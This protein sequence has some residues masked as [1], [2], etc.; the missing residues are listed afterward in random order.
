MPANI[1][2]HSDEYRDEMDLVKQWMDE[3]LQAVTGS[4][5]K[6]MN[7]YQSF[8]SWQEN[9]GHHPMTSNVFYRLLPSHLGKSIKKP[10]GSYYSGYVVKPW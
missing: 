4:S 8:R 2:R 10:A 3:S 7:L 6:A 9:N 5:T 1:K